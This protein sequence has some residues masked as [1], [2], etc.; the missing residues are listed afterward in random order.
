MVFETLRSGR[1]SL[2]RTAELVEMTLIMAPLRLGLGESFD[3]GPT[4]QSESEVGGELNGEEYPFELLDWTDM[5]GIDSCVKLAGA[6]QSAR[7]RF[8]ALGSDSLR[9]DGIA[10]L[11]GGLAL[12]SLDESKGIA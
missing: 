4:W 11:R 10:I 7:A 9:V 3:E 2:T 1:M 8:A 5:E 12:R 6:E